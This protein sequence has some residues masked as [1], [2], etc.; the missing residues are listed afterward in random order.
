LIAEPESIDVVFGLVVSGPAALV[1]GAGNVVV[2]K[3]VTNPEGSEGEAN[4]LPLTESS[5]DELDEDAVVVGVEDPDDDEEGLSDEIKGIISWADVI[6]KDCVEIQLVG[7]GV[8][9]RVEVERAEGFVDT[10]CIKSK[11]KGAKSNV[12]MTSVCVPDETTD[13]KNL[14]WNWSL[15][16][17]TGA[18]VTGSPLSML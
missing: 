7:E 18:K 3:M 12:D 2:K 11:R 13:S 9:M 6:G 14:T 15:F 4:G 10:T 16:G 17:F 1:L 8:F 5:I